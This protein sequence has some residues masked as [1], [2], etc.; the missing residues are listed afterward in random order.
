M[1][2]T[3]LPASIVF[4]C[5]ILAWPI[6][7]IL[8]MPAGNLEAQLLHV[9]ANLAPFRLNFVVACLIGPTVLWMLLVYRRA[10]GVPGGP[11]WATALVFYAV[12]I[13]LITVSYGSQVVYLPRLLETGDPEAA[14]RWFFYNDQSIAITINQTAYL[15]WSVATVVLF[16]PGLARLPA[17]ARSTAG[18]LLLSSG[19]QIVATLGM[20]IGLGALT[21][22][23]FPSGLLLIPVGVMILVQAVRGSS[24]AVPR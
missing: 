12:Y 5:V 7:A 15:F 8:T 13:V 21:S 10:L 4:L 1:T 16:A 17:L 2:K 3:V 11:Q 22:L 19:M 9:S 6:L 23:S 20:V 14:M 24:A 18:L